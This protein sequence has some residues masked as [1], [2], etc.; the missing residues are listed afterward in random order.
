MAK[1][2]SF[3]ELESLHELADPWKEDMPHASRAHALQGL[4]LARL[5]GA[6]IHELHKYLYS[7]YW[8]HSFP[9]QGANWKLYNA[10]EKE[11]Q[12]RVVICRIL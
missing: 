6:A 2:C 4:A 9:C 7:F 10:L 5:F 11:I 1:V 12:F 3:L 8:R